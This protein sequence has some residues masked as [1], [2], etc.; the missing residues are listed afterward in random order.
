MVS[1]SVSISVEGVMEVIG[2]FPAGAPSTWTWR[3]RW[4]TSTKETSL[5]YG[6][7]KCTLVFDAL[8]CQPW[9]AGGVRSGPAP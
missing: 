1:D 4:R 9:R 8:E 3:S 6:R 7:K 2:R 5:R